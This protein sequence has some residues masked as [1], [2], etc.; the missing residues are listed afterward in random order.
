MTDRS[1]QARRLH[2]LHHAARPLLLFNAWDAGSAK[3]VADGGA[4]ALAT[5]SWAVAAAHGLPDGEQLPLQATLDVVARIAAACELPLTVDL[6][7]GHGDP[8][9][10]VR[11]AIAAGAVGANLEDGLANGRLRPADEQ[12][13]LLAQARAAAA[14]AGMPAFFLNARTD[15]FLQHSRDAHD[16]ALMD[17]ALAR[18]R[19][20][21]DAGADGFFAPGLVDAGSIE[22]LVRGCPLPVNLMVMPGCPPFAE[23]AKLG[24]ARVSHGP[25]PYLAAMQALATAFAHAREAVGRPDRTPTEGARSGG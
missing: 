2:A 23:L 12:A 15:L 13:A 14:A 8:A 20:Y 5:S 11:H 1:A 7:R 25:G 3:A 6:E 9:A 17:Q 16:G 19:A 18:A 10:A 21:A 24:V 4:D 22:A